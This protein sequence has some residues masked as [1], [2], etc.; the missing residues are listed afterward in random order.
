MHYF[1]SLTSTK[2]NKTE[3]NLLKNPKVGGVI[4]FG[5]NILGYETTKTLIKSIKA[6]K[7]NIK[8]AVDEEGGIVSR[9]THLIPNYSQPYCSKLNIKDV[10]KYYKMRSEF[11]R[12]IDIDINFAPVVDIAPT[13]TSYMYKR[14]YGSDVQTVIEFSK[15]CA[16]EQKKAGIASCIKH[17]PGHGKT[18]RNSHKELPVIDITRRMGKS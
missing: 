2:L 12:D 18:F 11:L 8:I 10:Q 4:L 17:F 14:S 16:G 7:E 9:F 6:I 13:E 15:I 3:I 1:I 5:K